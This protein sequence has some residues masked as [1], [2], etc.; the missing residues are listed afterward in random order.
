MAFVLS[1]TPTGRRENI[2]IKQIGG[3]VFPISL[4]VAGNTLLRL[5]ARQ[6]QQ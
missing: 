4:K 1:P 3:P 2:V 5:A 6:L